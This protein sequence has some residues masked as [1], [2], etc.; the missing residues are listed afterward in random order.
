LNGIAARFSGRNGR[1]FYDLI[2]QNKI[3]FERFPEQSLRLG[4]FDLNY[5]YNFDA[6][7]FSRRS[8]MKIFQ[9]LQNKIFKD[10][11]SHLVKM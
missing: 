3:K 2:K 4:R 9:E 1:F 8:N 11:L 6:S 5:S 7:D 10:G